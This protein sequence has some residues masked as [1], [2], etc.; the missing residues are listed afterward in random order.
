MADTHTN[1][2]QVRLRLPVPLAR[3]GGVIRIRGDKPQRVVKFDWQ[4][5]AV[6]AGP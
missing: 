5:V 2:T 4:P 1:A 6:S 3:G